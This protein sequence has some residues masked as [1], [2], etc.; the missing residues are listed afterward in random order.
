[1]MIAKE[2]RKKYRDKTLGTIDANIVVNVYLSSYRESFK[3]CRFLL[4]EG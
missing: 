3:L 2:T 4:S 1:M